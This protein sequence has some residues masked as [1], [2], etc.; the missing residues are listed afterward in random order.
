MLFKCR[1]IKR[2]AL[3]M[4]G[5]AVLPLAVRVTSAQSFG[6]EALSPR[7]FSDYV[8]AAPA[9]GVV[10]A[11]PRVDHPLVVVL[12]WRGDAGWQTDTTRRRTAPPVGSAMSVGASSMTEHS[13]NVGGHDLAFRYDGRHHTIEVLGQKYDTSQPVALLIDRADANGGPAQVISVVRLAN[14]FVL[15][16]RWTDAPGSTPAPRGVLLVKSLR[17]YPEIDAFL[18]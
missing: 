12:L 5:V 17:Q 8:F 10:P 18:R 4:I 13:H 11:D 2:S 7:I 9:K 3:L 14:P 15:P 1:R 16:A 6:G